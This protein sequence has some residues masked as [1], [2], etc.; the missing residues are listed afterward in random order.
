MRLLS[1][2]FVAAL[3]VNLIGLQVA[4]GQSGYDLYG[5]ART[6]GLGYASTALTTAAGPQ[7]NPAAGALTEDRTVIFYG[8]EAYRLS[9]LRYGAVHGSWPLEWGTIST[10]GSTFGGDTYRE[11]HYSLSYARGLEFGTTRQFQV[12][13]RTRYYHTQID[14]YGGAGALGIHLGLLVSLLPSLHFGAHV[15]N[16]NGP[17]LPNDEALPQTLSV[18]IQYRVSDQF[19]VVTDLFK[20]LAFPASV[21][22]GLEVRPVQALA[23]RA[24]IT[25]TPTRFTGGVGVK[26]SRIQAHVAVE[27]HAELGLSPAASLEVRW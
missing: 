13:L 4:C 10:G 15:T 22:W 12:G 6:S 8:R 26:L 11:I 21:R 24:G 3:I 5:N 9:L 2:H 23:L 27:H 18:G 14:G 16:V 19:F 1:G 25:S 20:D 7:A 17:T